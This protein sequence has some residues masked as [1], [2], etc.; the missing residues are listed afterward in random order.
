MLYCFR[1]YN[2]VGRIND[3]WETIIKQQPTHLSIDDSS[4]EVLSD[5][6]KSLSEATVAK[7]V[8]LIVDELKCHANKKSPVTFSKCV[9]E[10]SIC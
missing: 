3:L 6:T 1:S 10:S 4:L 8:K 9:Y 5:I 2:K 7:V